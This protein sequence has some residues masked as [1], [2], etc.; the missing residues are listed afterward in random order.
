MDEVRNVDEVHHRRVATASIGHAGPRTPDKEEHP[1]RRQGRPDEPRHGPPESP[2]ELGDAER[3]GDVHQGGD[4]DED[5]RNRD[6]RV[7]R[8]PAAF[9]T[10]CSPVLRGGGSGQTPSSLTSVSLLVTPT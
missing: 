5:R 9:S 2:S 7:R 1:H 6:T 8:T 4:A 3:D 10:F